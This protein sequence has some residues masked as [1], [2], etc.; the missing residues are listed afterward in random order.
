MRLLVL[1]ILVIFISTYVEQSEAFFLKKSIGGK[2]NL[3]PMM[4]ALT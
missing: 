1:L 3:S 2:N 4:N